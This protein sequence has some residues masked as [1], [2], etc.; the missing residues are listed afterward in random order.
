[1]AEEINE[2]KKLLKEKKLIIGTENTIKKLRNNDLKKIW[3]S[4]NV[5]SDVK[6]SIT[7]Y[8]GM[9]NTEIVALD[10]PNDEFGVLCKKQFSVSVA[11]VLKGEN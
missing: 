2:I 3:F 11:S 9:N 4:S 5:P 6:E 8:A 10:I 1:M 7:N